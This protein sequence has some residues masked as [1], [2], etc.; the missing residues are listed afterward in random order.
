MKKG[1]I[2]TSHQPPDAKPHPGEKTQSNA[3]VS[4]VV[5]NVKRR[6]HGTHSE[7]PRNP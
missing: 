4:D 2:P 3:D 7:S 5:P 1:N 6:D